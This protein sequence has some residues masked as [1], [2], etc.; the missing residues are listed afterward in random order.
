MDIKSGVA[1][2]IFSLPQ[3]GG[4]VK[5]LGEKFQTDLNTGTGSYSVPLELPA[6]VNGMTPS[7]SL[8]YN[9]G[10]GNGPFGL[11]WG[12][13]LISITR[14]ISRGVPIYNDE[15]DTFIFGTDE[16]VHV[17]DN[18]YRPEIEKAFMRILKVDDHW[19]VTDK[20][21]KRYLLGT[22]SESRIAFG[23]EDKPR[24][25][26][27]ALSEIID[28]NG[29]IIKYHYKHDSGQ[30]YLNRI[31]YSIYRIDFLYQERPDVISNHRS[32]YKICT[33]LRCQEIQIH[34][35]TLE[36]SLIRSYKLEY[37]QDPLSQLSL[38]HQITCTDYQYQ[39]G[40]TITKNR[41]PL[42]FD[43][44]KFDPSKRFLE[45][46]TSPVNSPPAPLSDGNYELID[47]T[48]GGLPGVL[49]LE[50]G[51]NR[52]WRNCGH[53]QW[54]PPRI[55]NRV[56]APISL[57][58][59]NVFFAD[60][61]GNG[62]VDLL[63]FDQPFTGFYPNL[64]RE[65]WGSMVS[66]DYAPI[67]NYQDINM[68][69]NARF[70]DLDGDGIIDLLYTGDSH[71]YLYYNRGKDG[72]EP[73][74]PVT[75]QHDASTFPNVFLSDP[76]V[77]LADMTGDGFQDVIRITS[78]RLEYWP[79]LGNGRWGTRVIMHK[80]PR[81]E[82]H[83]DPTRVYVTDING[84]GLADVVYVGYDC[85]YYWINQSGQSF[86]EAQQIQFTPLT[87]SSSSVRIV[88][89]KGTGTAGVLWSYS[90]GKYM[91]LDFTGGIKPYLLS[92]IDNHI[93]LITEIEYRP[94]TEFY[95]KD[96]KE[97][98][99]WRTF[100]PF[101]VQTVSK[102]T[103]TDIV[104]GKSTITEVSYH[105]GHYDGLEQEFCGFG[106]AEVLTRGDE[107]TPDSLTIT[108]FH[109][110]QTE[111][112]SEVER[113]RAKALR[114]VALK[115]E[116]YGLDGSEK[117]NQ[118]YKIEEN[119]WETSILYEDSDGKRIVFPSLVEKII[120]HSERT[121]Q[122]RIIRNYYTYDEYGNV[123]EERKIGEQTNANGED[124][125]LELITSIEY[126]I[127]ETKWLLEKP[128][129]IIQRGKD[130]KVI[131]D[132]RLYYDGAPFEGLP[133][134]QIE[135]GNLTRRQVLVL[136][137]P[138][139]P[140]VYG[141]DIPDFASLGYQYSPNLMA[142]PGYIIN[143]I[144]LQYDNYGNPVAQMDALGRVTQINYDDHHLLPVEVIDPKGYKT[145]VTY[146]YRTQQITTFIDANNNQYQFT[147]DPHA[148]VEKIV[149]P[150]DNLDYPTITY[151]YWEDKLPT[152]RVTYERLHSGEPT[153]FDTYEYF[154]GFG[155]TIQKR[156]SA[157]DGKVVVS[158]EEYNVQGQVA[159]KYHPFFSI[160]YEYVPEEQDNGNL[161][162][163]MKYDATGRIISATN[164]EGSVIRVEYT[165]WEAIHYDANDTD[166]TT[167]NIDRG[168]FNTPKIERYDA[169]LRLI[170]VTELVGEESFSTRY[171]YDLLG[172][173]TKVI[174]AKGRES[175]SIIYD[176]L[177]NRLRI[178]HIDAGTKIY[179]YDAQS[180]V[181]ITTDSK[182]QIVHRSYD[183]LNRL[184]EV[185]LGVNGEI[186]VEQHIYD[187]G[188]GKNLVRRLSKVIDTSGELSFSYDARGNVIEKKR[189]VKGKDTP[190]T[191]RSEYNLR[192][193]I[194]KL[195]YPDNTEVVY[196]YNA[197]ALL[198]SIPGYIETIDYNPNGQRVEVRYSNGVI[199][200]YVYDKQT[201]RLKELKTA[202]P[203]GGVYQHL[204]YEYDR[205]GNVLAIHDLI[206][207]NSHFQNSR[208]FTYDA[209][210]RLTGSYGQSA[211]GP[212][213]YT[214]HYDPLGNFIENPEFINK[215]LTYKTGNNQVTGYLNDSDEVSLFTYDNNGN[216]ATAP[217]MQLFY[218]YRNQLIR[219]QK[220]DG[221]VVEFTYDY[222]GE[223][224]SK[225]VTKGNTQIEWFYINESYEIQNGA[226]T[227]YIFD[228][229]TRIAAIQ[230]NGKVLFF[231]QDHLGS[232]VVITAGD[233]GNLIQQQEY[234]PFGA[235]CYVSSNSKTAYQYTGQA[236]EEEL[237]LYYYKRRY[238]HPKLGRFITP[239]PL[240]FY[241]P[242]HGQ[243]IPQSLN[244]YS[245]VL[246]NPLIYTDPSGLGFWDAFV[247]VVLAVA[248]V[249][250]VGIVTGG[251][252]LIVLGVATAAGAIIGGIQGGLGRCS[253]RS[254]DWFHCWCE[255]C[256][257]DSNFRASYWHYPWIYHLPWHY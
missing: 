227:K 194:C 44:T 1:P 9:T 49:Q 150:G 79:Y 173:I 39:N 117:Q 14:K 18:R 16:L 176:L 69:A 239:D 28:T 86:S 13:G 107:F 218:D 114:R 96:L 5:G 78:G 213:N 257:G 207:E 36:Q 22:T 178:Q 124:T 231:H 192:G 181:V 122:T 33:R 34:I 47:L 29:N 66:Y 94:S 106:R 186:L 159:K 126:C 256:S 170:S 224:I 32:G 225:R 8:G 30:L 240:F 31:E 21:G 203:A 255:L 151:E 51:G 100:L 206:E 175:S 127:N 244:L 134:G 172:R 210:Y 119:R 209:L 110:G 208:S 157:E 17:G 145:S 198:D 182:G 232:C 40:E 83:Y 23:K 95:L 185:R 204:K 87:S 48:G 230:P 63:V 199:T 160:G 55:L 98:K 163:T 190:F 137:D 58:Q 90:G 10:A 167:E 211:N 42:T 60:M 141:S 59:K 226:I 161:M 147:Y 120:R 101:P 144:R 121:N 116:V 82:R 88:D 223:R 109:L 229:R 76:H 92:R 246:N 57:E 27:W 81:F 179:T 237:E 4:S 250:V 146:N 177:G 15:K 251:T 221:T 138:L 197:G 74:K 248:A 67:L 41:P 6:G 12:I 111:G 191:F 65:E 131:T 164:G 11:G 222:S 212:Y 3:G 217:E 72:W 93:G 53:C 73:P 234:Y 26:L 108:W 245:Y 188:D 61:E 129:R 142:E 162:M 183:E 20:S 125:S 45:S 115:Y 193:Q 155:K 202:H 214:Y 165:P 97:R 216:M 241:L 56:P 112:L 113:D 132:V 85:V 91:Y 70:V 200:S 252:G 130:G 187:T 84:D 104:T 158:C 169:W 143:A 189:L 43:Y 64:G 68:R 105:D 219:V 37:T 25:F 19:E 180:N 102:V 139:V 154:N 140:Q 135:K 24:I 38:L 171:E 52:Y 99:K 195:T 205:V 152:S 149:K 118:P 196:K 174:D 238:Y 136:P 247:G 123:L 242:E 184:T 243:N 156:T 235:T 254:Y 128:S 75:R 7:L 148:R 168:H 153:T 236:Y 71:F 46:F 35:T 166:D 201:S 2:E 220:D 89:M 103:Y 215:E 77:H 62:T 50:N 228:D 249:A 253:S 233:N 133:T 54:A 80:A